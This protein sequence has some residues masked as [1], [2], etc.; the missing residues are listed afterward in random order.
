[1]GL[2]TEV[3]D[4][5]AGGTASVI[6]DG[7]KSYFPPKMSDTEK[8]NLEIGIKKMNAD[9]EMSLKEVA[10]KEDVEFNKRIKDMEG[11]A[12]DLKTIWGIGHIII[13][14]RGAQ[15]PIW[16]LSTLYMDY[17]VFSGAWPGIMDDTQLK[18]LLIVINFLVL[19]F[20]FGERAVKNVMPLII[21]F[22]GKGK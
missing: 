9:I 6:M 8:A 4:F 13:L 22:L 18:T 3:A 16:G 15:R 5:F 21:Q 7:V 20:L 14:A 11:T 10:L 19:G 17:Q 2:F 12:S 1:M